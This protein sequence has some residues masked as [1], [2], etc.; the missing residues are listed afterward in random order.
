MCGLT[1]NLCTSVVSRTLVARMADTQANKK[2]SGEDRSKAIKR[3]SKR[4]ASVLITYLR[5]V[6]N[7]T[8]LKSTMA[9]LLNTDLLGMNIIFTR[10]KEILVQP[11]FIFEYINNYENIAATVT[12]AHLVPI[13]KNDQKL[14]MTYHSYYY[15][16][17]Y[18]VLRYQTSKYSAGRTMGDFLHSRRS[19]ESLFNKSMYNIVRLQQV[20]YNRWYEQLDEET[21]LPGYRIRYREVASYY[22]L[23]A[24]LLREKNGK[25]AT[26][27][28][29]DF[30]DR[31][32]I[33]EEDYTHDIIMGAITISNITFDY[34]YGARALT[35]IME[36]YR[37]KSK[38]GPSD[39]YR[40]PRDY[41]EPHEEATFVLFASRYTKDMVKKIFTYGYWKEDVLTMTKLARIIDWIDAMYDLQALS[42]ISL[43]LLETQIINVINGQTY[44]DVHDNDAVEWLEKHSEHLNLTDE[45]IAK[46]K[47]RVAD[48]YTYLMMARIMYTTQ[49]YPKVMHIIE[50]N[51]YN[52][53]LVYHDEYETLDIDSL[54]PSMRV[55]YSTYVDAKRRTFGDLWISRHPRG[56]GIRGIH[57]M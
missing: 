10:Y 47:T 40:F 31:Y 5:N 6:F 57:W 33:K 1:V 29:R 54:K 45:Q 18:H 23:V 28:A 3:S 2:L 42:A 37:N 36:R 49:Y 12:N 26:M 4:L 44:D 13:P 30:V 38:D 50:A 22:R 52:R 21:D 43:D 46:Y 55:S 17:I 20:K 27:A 32:S 15:S 24:N 48:G 25:L 39:N 41:I 14:Q 35:E 7:T 9:M 11:E 56:R 19:K 34:T 16:F 51:T 53:A 8:N